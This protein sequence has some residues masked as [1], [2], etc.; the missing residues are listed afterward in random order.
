ML[1]RRMMVP[2]GQDLESLFVERCEDSFL[3]TEAETRVGR[4]T[5]PVETAGYDW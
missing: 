1:S 5:L 3:W 2:L 4:D